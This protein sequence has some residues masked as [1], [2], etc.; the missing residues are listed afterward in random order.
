[1]CASARVRGLEIAF[2][3]EGVGIPLV[4]LHAFPLN[5]TMWQEQVEALR[6]IC[7]I[8]APDMRG[9]GE[10]AGSH[11][12][13]TMEEMARDVAALLDVLHVERAVIG[14]LSMG[15]YVAFAFLRLFPER[16]AGLILADTR[17]QSD[18]EDGRRTREENAR[19]A[20]DEG[21]EPIA[22][23]MLPKLLSQATREGTPNLVARVR[24]MIVSAKP[25]S[26][27]AALRG[28]A[29]RQDQRDLLPHIEAPAL[30][31]VGSEDELTPPRDA[32]LMSSRIPHSQLKVLDGAAHLSNLERPI[33]FNAA[34]LD[35]LRQAPVR[36]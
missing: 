33:E 11:G 27:A 18:D 13:A 12:P 7:R 31:L 20:L 3:D 8:V 29:I 6:D 5:R 15:G 35:F 24:S 26:V 36:V 10:S 34:L 1:M 4:L 17:P 25:E 19:R 21:M 9:F 22:S 32:E 2:T 14:G 23:A 28:M 16:V 30:I